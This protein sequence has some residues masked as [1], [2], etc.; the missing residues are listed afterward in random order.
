MKFDHQ[1]TPYTEINSR[2]IKDLN[3]SRNTI[4]V[5]EENIGRKISDIP[6]SNILTD[7]PPKARDI[8]ERKNKWDRIKIKSICMAKENST[9]LQREPTVWEN[10]FTNDT[11]DKGLISKIYK[12]L[13]RL[14]SRKT[15]NPIKKWAKDL[16]T[17]FSKED[18]QRA[19]R[20][21]KRC[22][23]RDAKPSERCILK[24]Q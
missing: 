7:M 9:K 5:L 20:H 10:I 24:P 23:E 3:I 14:H 2:W 1:L 13:T 4:K 22:S 19:Q 17:H 6:R 12:E 11:S 21:M 16:N 15:N 18:I 8:K